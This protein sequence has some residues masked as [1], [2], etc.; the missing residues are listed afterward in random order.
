MRA[1]PQ[2][3]QQYAAKNSKYLSKFTFKP[4]VF[5]QGF[6]LKVD[7]REQH[8]PLFLDKPPKGLVIVRDTCRVGDYQILGLENS[9][10]IEKKYYADLYTYCTTEWENKTKK[11]L[12]TMKSMISNGGW[13]AILIDNRESDIFKWQEHTRTNPESIRGA[14]NVIRMR[15][16][17]HVYFSP[18][19]EHSTRFILDSAIKWYEIKHEL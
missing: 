6:I 12:E 5:P 16:G 11:K 4:H 14:L 8:S 13:C 9:F 10:T 1:T 19:K 17:I 7:T 2:T 3:P 15:Y 18:T